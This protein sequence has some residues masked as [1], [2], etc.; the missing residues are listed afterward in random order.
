MASLTS[1]Y[2]HQ[3]GLDFRARDLRIMLVLFLSSPWNLRWFSNKYVLNCLKQFCLLVKEIYISS[4]GV[5]IKQNL[6]FPMLLS[7]TFA[8]QL[9]SIYVTFPSRFFHQ[10]HRS[11]KVKYYISEGCLV[12]QQNPLFLR[13]PNGF[14][15]IP[16]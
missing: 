16:W 15:E 10:H 12:S 2:V 11:S 3:L 6:G 14:L 9:T 4:S 1:E 8:W 13:K 7:L 5:I